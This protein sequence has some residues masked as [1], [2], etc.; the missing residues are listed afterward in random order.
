[1]YPQE[2][3]QR[4]SRHVRRRRLVAAADGAAA[5]A[6]RHGKLLTQDVGDAAAAE[7]GLAQTQARRDLT[8]IVIYLA[9]NSSNTGYR[10][11]KQAHN[12]MRRHMPADQPSKRTLTEWRLLLQPS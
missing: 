3:R 8:R 1:M 6:S 11:G 7:L 5:N 4:S 2:P 9:F 12:V 10:K